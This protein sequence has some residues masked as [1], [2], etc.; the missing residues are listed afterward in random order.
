MDLYSLKKQFLY[1]F[2]LLL[3]INC[4]NEDPPIPE[5]AVFEAQTELISLRGNNNQ[6]KL[7]WKPVVI[8]KFKSYKIYRLDS[9]TDEFMSP[10][11][12]VNSGELI[13]E[14]T[15]NLTSV[16]T[17]NAVPF[18]SFIGYAVVTEYINEDNNIENV[19]S[20]NHLSYENENLSFSIT[21]LVK[22]ED[23]SL[24]LEWEQDANVGFGNYTIYAVNDAYLNSEEVFNNEKILKVNVSQKDNSIIDAT[25]YT[26]GQIF[27]AVSKVINGK[28]IRSKN[29]LSIQ[30]PRALN[31]KP[32]QTLKNPY[33][34]NEMIIINRDG[35]EVLFYNIKSLSKDTV[36][37]ISKDTVAVNGEIFFCSIGKF[38]GVD[39]LYVP[40]KDGKVFV[41][42]LISHKIKKTINLQTDYNILS[43][44]VINNHILFHEKHA[45]ADI[46]GMFVYDRIN[47]K[48]LNR[49]GTF[50]MSAN[51]KLVYGTENYFFNLSNDGLEYGSSSAIS[52]LNINGDQVSKD[53]L[54]NSSIAD[55][56]LFALSD[57]KTFF[58]STKYG[59]QS[60]VN[61]E[62][63]TEVTTKK[64]YQDG[65]FG[66]AKIAS[67]NKHIYFS[68]PDYSRIEV[69][70]KNNFTTIIKQYKTTGIPLLI[71]VFQNQ[72][73][74][75]N[76]LKNSY[77]IET[78]P[79]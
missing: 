41:I 38:N 7:I 28:R 77:Y 18:N 71:E 46:G 68:V 23:G 11:V 22:L 32:E 51:S 37:V 34:E 26:N 76:Q 36:A 67:D 8:K 61:Y 70:E 6:L 62:N 57:D 16:Y 74:S 33:N 15:N 63:F 39:D 79:Q 53:F 48:V 27:Y 73:I 4:S 13:F 40:S 43:A 47:D 64:Y 30:N 50:G 2:T 59:Y 55:S 35:G 21:S 29:Y 54:F 31:F 25:P 1:F 75:L 12:I 52:R 49:N 69:F 19:S 24:K 20:V 45:Y 17:D 5:N 60:D 72:I 78:I 56:R 10:N 9:H 14:G 58:V 3:F 66:D 65:F 44:I 42:D